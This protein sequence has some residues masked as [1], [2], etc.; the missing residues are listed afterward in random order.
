MKLIIGNWGTKSDS[1]PY[2]NRLKGLGIKKFYYK[3]I[4]DKFD[5][6]VV[7]VTIVL[8][9]KQVALLDALGYKYAHR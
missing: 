8:N 3:N 6:Y 1:Q 4:K 2:I 9:K 5:R 7:Q